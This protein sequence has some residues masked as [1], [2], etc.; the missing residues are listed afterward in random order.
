VPDELAGEV[1]RISTGAKFERQAVAFQCVNPKPGRVKSQRPE[2]PYPD[3]RTLRTM[4]TVDSGIRAV[5]AGGRL[6][7]G[8]VSCAGC[9]WRGVYRAYPYGQHD[10]QTVAM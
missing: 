10:T 5:V 9:G 1:A 8:G 7:G 2:G 4:R 6:V 3:G